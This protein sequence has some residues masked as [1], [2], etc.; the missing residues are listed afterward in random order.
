MRTLVVAYD[1]ARPEQNRPQVAEA[2]MSLGEQWARPLDNVWYLRA[3][4]DAADVEARLATLLDAEDGLL[5]QEARG[6]AVMAN[7]GLRWFRRRQAT[8]SVVVPFPA[9]PAKLA[10]ADR[11]EQ[12]LAG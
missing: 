10:D 9:A 1:L 5:V 4:I 2:L 7:T 11:P 8:T 12:R 6:A 3:D